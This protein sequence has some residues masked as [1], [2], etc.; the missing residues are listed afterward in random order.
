MNWYSV[1]V[2]AASWALPNDRSVFE[3]R[4]AAVVF[5]IASTV[6]SSLTLW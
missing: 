6:R 5:L 4:G 3:R 2:V 1:A